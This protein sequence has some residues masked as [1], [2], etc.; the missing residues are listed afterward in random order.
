MPRHPSRVP[1]RRVLR[2]ALVTGA[3]R[4]AAVLAAVLVVTM[5]LAGSATAGAATIVPSGTPVTL[6]F[7]QMGLPGNLSLNGSGSAVTVQIPVPQGLQ[8]EALSGTIEVPTNVGSGYISVT[9][10]T[11]QLAAVST[12]PVGSNQPT[13]NLLV[14]L[15]AA[16]QVDQRIPLTLQYR[17]T[18]GTRFCNSTQSFVL[19]NPEVAF[20][21]TAVAPTSVA[22]FFPPILQ[23][24]IIY[25]P[26]TPTPGEQSAALGLAAAIA[27][28]YRPQAVQLSVVS[29][30]ESDP[31]PVA[32]SLT[33]FARA[34]VIRQSGS[35]GLT[36][37]N[38]GLRGTVLVISGSAETLPEQTQ[39]LTRV[40]PLAQGQSASVLKGSSGATLSSTQ[41]TFSQLGIGGTTTLSGQQTIALGLDEASFGGSVTSMDVHLQAEYTPPGPNEKATAM[42]TAGSTVL[43]SWT[44]D[45]SG[46]LSEEF[47]VP[48]PAISR[49]TPLAL[50]VSY[51][52][53][54]GCNNGGRV[55]NF[56]VDPRS[57]VSVTTKTGGSGGFPALPAAMLPTFQVALADNT[58]V[59]LDA[60]VQVVAGMQQMSSVLLDPSVVGLSTATGSDLPVLVVGSSEA[61]RAHFDPP[62]SSLS[63][64][65]L[66]AEF[67]EPMSADV[68]LPVAAL[69]VF[70]QSSH[71][72]TVV[73]VSTSGSWDMVTHLL[74]SLGDSQTQW[75]SLTGD[76]LA[77]TPTGT[78]VNLTVRAGGAATTEYGVPSSTPPIVL[79]GVLGGCALALVILLVAFLLIRRARHGQAKPEG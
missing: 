40:L 78:I 33:Q 73:M 26:P 75:S 47:T 70:D 64:T 59:E 23:R 30:P 41:A 77:T 54:G 9:S 37:V 72:R 63:T 42:A 62:L 60:A 44:L 14:S 20:G 21:G 6:S 55:M 58:A 19:V 2:A 4:G 74:G 10:G 50:V 7:P 27:E 69:Q 11:Q 67:H 39:L 36:V 15:A 71:Q 34:V 65:T 18:S 38:G 35:T 48:S 76:V 1:V 56:T 45:G 24:L 61:L 8:A 3:A 52:P 16:Q 22:N 31:L 5:A 25:V 57:W 66:E 79:I 51:W 13:V 53:A 68:T 49:S 28:R 17:Q 12:P 29:L 43:G 32:P 46:Q